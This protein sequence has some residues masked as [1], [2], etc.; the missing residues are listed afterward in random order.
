MAESSASQWM[1]HFA[2]RGPAGRTSGNLPGPTLRKRGLRHVRLDPNTGEEKETF[3]LGGACSEIFSGSRLAK[4]LA[5]GAEAERRALESLANDDF[6]E[7]LSIHTSAGLPPALPDFLNALQPHLPWNDSDDWCCSLQLEGGSAVLAGV[8]MLV[9]LQRARGHT[10]RTKIAVAERSYH[11]P[12]ATAPGAPSAPLFPKEFQLVYPAP[13][14][15]RETLDGLEQ[16]FESFLKKHGEEIAVMLF[17]PQWGSSN[18]SKP[19]PRELLRRFIDSAHE[20]GILVLCDEIMCGL[21]RHGYGTMF[22]TKAWDLPADAVTFGKAV[23]SGVYPLS[24]VII[25]KGTQELQ[26]AGKGVMH[27]HTYAG[28]GQLALLASIEVL[29]MLSSTFEHIA[30]MSKLLETSLRDLERETDG[31]VRCFGQGLMWGAMFA[32]TVEDRVEAMNELKSHCFSVGV[33][34][35]FVPIGGFQIT[36]VLDVTEKDLKMGLERLAEC[37]RRVKASRSSN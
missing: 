14:V 4:V 13:T 11:G 22:V 12:A 6:A 21:G 16:E 10:G 29:N 19:W 26:A 28:A 30:K 1:S 37:V 36:P 33:W 5:P 9:Q 20:H 24:G 7:T 34:P 3:V 32:G 27:M 17:E 18:V 31:F 25:R 15:L 8:D 2:G 35:Y 23:A